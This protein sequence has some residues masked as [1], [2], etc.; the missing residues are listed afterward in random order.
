MNASTPDDP[1]IA[2]DA[3]AWGDDTRR[4]I[5]VAQR[6]GHE[7]F[8]ERAARVDREAAFPHDNFRDLREAG[9][10]SL[11][12]PRAFGG[13]GT[14]LATTALVCAEI[15]RHCRLTARPSCN[16]SSTLASSVPAA[17]NLSATS[18]SRRGSWANQT[19][20]CAPSPSTRWSLKRPS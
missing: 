4:L 2:G 8:A 13:H 17:S 5:A 12:V 20:A 1:S 16:H 19:V 11:A 14:D 7:Q 15:G 10:L 6:L 3:D 9:L 18:R